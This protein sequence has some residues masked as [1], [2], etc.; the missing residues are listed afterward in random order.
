MIDARTVIVV[1]EASTIG[2][3][4]LDR[5]YRHAQT[6]G[7]TVRT[8]GDPH[9][10]RSVEAGGL[11]KHLTETF[12]HRTPVLDTN[13]RQTGPGMAEVR[14][15]LD[16]YRNGLIDQA[17][18]RLDDDGRIVTASSWDGLLDQ[19]AA[20]W[21]VDHERHLNGQAAPSQMIA[22][23][24][25]DRHALNQRAQTLL[26]AS[27]QLG[28]PVPIGD[29][30][31]HIGDRIVA[32][33]TNRDLSTDGAS[34][35]EHVI[36]GS[37]GTVIGFA[38]N[39]NE[40]RAGRRLRRARPHRTPPSTSS[41]PR[42]A[43][44]AAVGSHRPTS[45]PPTRPKAR[46]TTP[47]ATSPRPTP[48]TPKACT[49]RSPEAAT[50]NAPTPLTPTT[51]ATSPNSPS[52][53]TNAP[54]PK[55]SPSRSTSTAAP[56]S[57]P[58]STPTPPRPHTTPACPLHEDRRHP[59]PCP[60]PA[61]HRRRRHQQPRPHH[62]RRPRPPTP[63]G[64]RP[65]HLGSR[66]RRGR[67]LPGPMATTT[68]HPRRLRHPTNPRRRT[69]PLRSLRPS[70]GRRR[71]RPRHDSSTGSPSTSCSTAGE[72]P[73]VSSPT[74]P[75]PNLQTG[76]ENLRRARRQHRR[77]P[78]R[79]RPQPRPASTSP[80]PRGQSPGDAPTRPPSTTPP[81]CS[82][83]PRHRPAQL[84]RH[85]RPLPNDASPPTAP[86]YSP[87]APTRPSSPPPAARSTG[88]STTPSDHPAGYLTRRRRTH[89][90]NNR[91][92]LETWTRTARAIETYRHHTGRTPATG[93]I[94][95]G[96]IAAAIGP[97]PTNNLKAWTTANN[98]IHDFDHP[99]QREQVL[100]RTR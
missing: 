41:P 11:W 94:G 26:R 48:S 59:S 72:P 19:M 66:C 44:D 86:P 63:T 68:G 96:R 57:P 77:S 39:R 1:D 97:K 34:R 93:P 87:D 58:S 52:S 12:A 23:R 82:T 70:P 62:R 54:P 81:P 51:P 46:P 50:T 33:T 21:F 36:N 74:R 85:V 29:A 20:D 91:D 28:E 17:M 89:D 99:K 95:R 9:Q 35:R 3:R 42:S 47:A 8:I 2:N 100:R 16:D 18:R 15:A 64:T 6:T 40:P 10:H 98:A 78:R 24:N 53:P 71:R 5:L 60:R 92:K 88:A 83:P 80:R 7:A 65:R 56:T 38:G 27:G 67:H 43:P 31:F 69:G 37:Q 13:R 90:P 55:P 45:S 14:L 30:D 22:E 75:A 25:H 32:Q 61:T 76:T 49:S 73:H 4:Q 84:E 79:S